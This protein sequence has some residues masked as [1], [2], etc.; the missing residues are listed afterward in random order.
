MNDKNVKGSREREKA[1]FQP[2]GRFFEVQ[3]SFKKKFKYQYKLLILKK[4]KVLT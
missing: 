3:V 2:K 1:K 4:E